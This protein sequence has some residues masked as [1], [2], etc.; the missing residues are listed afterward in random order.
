LFTDGVTEARSGSLFFGA[1][2]VINTLRD[3]KYQSP[4]DIVKSV[5]DRASAFA[6]DEMGDDVCIVAFQR[7]DAAG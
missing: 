5:A 1:E 4:D 6:D 7:D 3:K 2:G